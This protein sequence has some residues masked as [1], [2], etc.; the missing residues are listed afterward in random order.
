[1]ANL[2]IP[3]RQYY[4]LVSKPTRIDSYA[5]ARKSAEWY[6]TTSRTTTITYSTLKNVENRIQRDLNDQEGKLRYLERSLSQAYGR[7]TARRN[8]DILKGV[9]AYNRV[10]L[11]FNGRTYLALYQEYATLV[12]ATQFTASIIRQHRLV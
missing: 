2:Y 12:A 1:M 9:V 3:W 4:P 7:D 10:G 8:A 11:T 5:V 6:P